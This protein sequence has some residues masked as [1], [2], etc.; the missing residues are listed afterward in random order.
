MDGLHYL[1]VLAQEFFERVLWEVGELG[2][3]REE[4]QEQVVSVPVCLL[5]HGFV[6]AEADLKHCA[7]ASGIYGCFTF[8]GQLCGFAPY[9]ILKHRHAESVRCWNV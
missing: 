3:L 2:R 1:W 4:G 7:F 5:Y 6:G 8:D 9:I